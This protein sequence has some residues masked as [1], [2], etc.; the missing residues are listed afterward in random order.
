MTTNLYLL[1]PQSNLHVGAGSSNYGIIDN[2]VQRDAI[3]QYPNIHASSLKG[4]LREFFEEALN[5]KTESN[6]IFGSADEG[7]GNCVFSEGHLLGL[8][9]RS[10]KRPYF[11][12]TSPYV[13][14]KFLSISEE[15]GYKLDED[16]KKDFKALSSLPTKTEKPAVIASSVIPDLKIED[17]TE[18]TYQNPP[19]SKIHTLLGTDIVLFSDEDF[20]YQC[21][22]YALPVL[23][24][25]HLENG[26]SQNLWY[27][28]V[29]P[30]MTRFYFTVDDYTPDTLF[31]TT[32]TSNTKLVQIGGNATVGYGRC[33]IT[34]L[35]QLIK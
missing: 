21:G 35:N 23:A 1:V 10:N 33:K 18:F 25:N 30:K 31:D 34:N 7:K 3:D 17:L 16:L 27:E 20:T 8:P 2:L 19:L 11:I 13:L 28:Q 24:R 4:A 26:I 6:K 15:F 29:V 9:V 22:D 5:L 14:K 12:A 32:L